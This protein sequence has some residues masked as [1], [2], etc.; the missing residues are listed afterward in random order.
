VD[1]MDTAL[2]QNP[3]TGHVAGIK[4]H[5]KAKSKSKIEKRKAKSENRKSEI[6]K[7]IPEIEVKI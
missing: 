7:P 6:E 5:R 3:L 2:K 1:P 4:P